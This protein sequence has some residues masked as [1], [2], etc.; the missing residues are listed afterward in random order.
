M[1]W[2]DDGSSATIPEANEQHL[3]FKELY[4]NDFILEIYLGD[5]LGS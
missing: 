1:V 2:N 3:F 4:Q 5:I